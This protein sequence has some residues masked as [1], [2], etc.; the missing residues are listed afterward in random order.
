MTADTVGGQR[1]LPSLLEL[2]VARVTEDLSVLRQY[3]CL[4]E[5]V[6]Y[7]V[8][9]LLRRRQALDDGAL[10]H[11]SRLARLR[12]FSLSGSQVTATGLGSI[13]S[14]PVEWLDVSNCTGLRHNAVQVIM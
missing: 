13:V 1:R 2:A 11:F 6:C 3:P 9:G 7:M 12:R 10:H 4:P 14:Q 8:L 5:D